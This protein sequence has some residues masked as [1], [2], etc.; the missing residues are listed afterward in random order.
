MAAVTLVTRRDSHTRHGDARGRDTLRPLKGGLGGVTTS[1]TD[2]ADRLERLAPSHR[3]PF[4][5][6][7]D[8]SELVAELRQVAAAVDGIAGPSRAEAERGTRAPEFGSLRNFPKG[9]RAGG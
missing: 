6:H 3:D 7:E 5:Y 2:I 8:K 9:G 1:L 4:R